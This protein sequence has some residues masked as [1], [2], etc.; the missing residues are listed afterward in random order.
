MNVEFDIPGTDAKGRVYLTWAP[1]EAKA[2]LIDGPNGG[3]PVN[4]ILRNSGVGGRLVFDT[5]RSD[6]GS[7]T[8]RL[9][10]PADGT[11]VSFWVAGE[12]QRPSLDDG[13]A[14][15]EAVRS[16]SSEVL[17]SKAVM[18]RIRKNAEALKSTERDRF[19]RAFGKLNSGGA[20]RFRDF[21]E[22]HV[23]TSVPEAHGNVGFLPWHRAYLL[24]L[25]RELQAIDPSVALHYWRFDQPASRLFTRRFIGV[26]NPAGR[27]EFTAGHS[28]TS[29]RTDNQ[30]GITR[31][32]DFD[33]DAA[34]A[35]LRTE[36]QTLALGGNA[37]NAT[38][39]QFDR[40]EG[41]P[42]GWAHGSFGGFISSLHMAARDPLFFM[43][44]GNV[45][46]LWAKWQWLHRRTDPQDPNAFAPAVPNRIGHRLGDTMWPWNGITTP[47]RPATA[48]GGGLAESDVV[49]APSASPRVGEMLDYQDVGGG[50]PLGFAYD[51]VPFEL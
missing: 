48:P 25:E 47:P 14:S 24:D 45:D 2:R 51:D 49:K 46:R 43:L 8:L 21:R 37:P 19:L 9:R 15:V 20:G 28:L 3:A 50:A 11:P 16:G 41:N 40:M 7:G 38:Y 31:S 23:S 39:A 18:V 26:P 10:L 34:P 33:V 32:M 12:F 44:H 4:V 27:V 36:Q 29:W 6:R 22:M 35:G 1:V 42:H 13:D 17:G 5:V 30:P